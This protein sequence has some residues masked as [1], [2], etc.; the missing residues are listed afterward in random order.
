MSDGDFENKVN[1][2][3]RDMEEPI[4]DDPDEFME[5]EVVEGKFKDD[6]NGLNRDQDETKN[7]Y[8]TEKGFYKKN[9]M[10]EFKLYMLTCLNL[11]EE[12]KRVSE[13][14][15][16]KLLVMLVQLESRQ[17]LTYTMKLL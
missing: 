1:E 9:Y 4:G 12:L 5:E 11:H 3:I 10:F 15:K 16:V 13:L 7:I 2:M 14:N 17:V 8:L 6:L